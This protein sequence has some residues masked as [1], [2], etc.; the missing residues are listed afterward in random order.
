MTPTVR[1]FHMNEGLPPL[2]QMQEELIDMMNILLG[3]VEPPIDKG[4]MTLMEVADAFYARASE[5]TMMIQ[6]DEREG[7]VLKGTAYYKFRTGE[8]RTFMDTA[9]RA[10]ELGSRRITAAQ[11]RFEAERTGRGHLDFDEMDG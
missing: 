7:V 5:L 4:I 8:L 1:A 3:R 9:K 6:A 2:P 11:L 10:A